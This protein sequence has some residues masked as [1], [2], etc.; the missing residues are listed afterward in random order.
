MNRIQKD[1]ISLICTFVLL[2]ISAPILTFGAESDLYSSP[3]IILNSPSGNIRLIIDT[4]NNQLSCS[5]EYNNKRIL[6]I[7]NLGIV[8][9]DTDFTNN[10]NIIR[11]QDNIINET[12]NMKSGKAASYTNKANEKVI[13][14]QKDNHYLDIYFRVYDD[15]IAYRY[16]FKENTS[17]LNEPAAFSFTSADYNAY[18]A[19]YEICYES[20]YTVNQLS[21]LNGT[22]GM[23]ITIDTNNCYVLLSEADLNGSYT[24]SAFNAYNSSSLYLTYEPKQ[25]QPVN[26]SADMFSPWRMAVIGDINTIAMTEMPE[27][28]CEPSKISDMNW[29]VPGVTDWTWFNGDP[30]N[31]PEVYKKYID[32]SCEMGWEYILLDEGWQPLSY[33][34]TGRK[35]YSGLQPW[36]YEV[37]EYAAAK[38]IGVIVWTASWDLDTAEKRQRL[39]EWANLGIK[40]VKVDFFNSETQDTLKLMDEITLTAAN[41]KLLVNYHGCTKPS[42]ERRTWPNLITREAVH[43]NEHFLSGEG[44]GP[45]AEHNCILPFT[46][47]AVGPMDYTP[48]LTNYCDKNFFSD[49]QKAALPI[50]FESGVQCMSDKP[51]IYRNSPA[52]EFLKDLPA[53]WDESKVIS[54][55]IGNYAA[56]MR[57]KDNTYY[58]GSICNSKQ[59]IDINL[60]FLEDGKYKFEMYSDGNS[61]TELVKYTGIVTNT[62][63]IT[64]PMLEH[65][66]GVI[67]LTPLSYSEPEIYDISGHWSEENI[68]KLA[69]SNRLNKFFYCNFNPDRYITRSEFIM[70]IND[71]FEIPPDFSETIFIDSGMSI[72]QRYITAAANRGIVKGVSE[73][74]FGINEYI[75]REDAATIIGRYLG[76]KD[77]TII[78]FADKSEI[79]EYAKR[80]VA[81]CNEKGL[82]QGYEDETFRP[83]NNITAAEA[84]AIISRI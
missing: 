35:T 30:T 10:I 80:Y 64:V 58:I 78:N 13:T 56:I 75:T 2:V 33:D 63:F 26:I 32:F 65:G 73:Y 3:N 14:L 66:G 34:D 4:S 61:D 42:G 16:G 21:S 67:K 38:N 55:S 1:I 62:D 68:L 5:A 36:T 23:P 51:N 29:I 76:L 74:E 69:S 59:S 46:R 9:S 70:L 39:T 79:S 83:R 43:G 8:F 17:A 12:Y 28:L 24:G 18:A 77:G 11:A 84:A 44:W 25:T 41:L 54:G 15:G 50:I 40:G 52:Y 45:T 82:I 6:Y 72:A 19:E 22:Y 37:L 20:R 49:G 47:N 48:E 60:Y 53:A 71:A 57:R 27:N 81:Q 7:T 31:D